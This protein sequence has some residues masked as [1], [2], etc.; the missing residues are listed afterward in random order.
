MFTADTEVFT[1]TNWKKI[2]DISG[3]DKLLV[4]NF[5]DE[6]SFIKPYS[7]RR[8]E[9]SGGVVELSGTRWAVNV[10]PD[11]VVPYSY[12]GRNGLKYRKRPALMVRGDGY[13]MASRKFR[14]VN[15]NDY[16]VENIEIIRDG[17]KHRTRINTEDWFRLCGYVICR[18]QLVKASPKRPILRIF[19]DKQKMDQEII[20]LGGI[21]DRIGIPWSVIPQNGSHYI[22]VGTRN[23]LSTRLHYRLGSMTRKEMFIPDKMIQSSRHLVD[24]LLDS[25]MEATTRIDTPKDRNFLLFTP[26]TNLIKSLDNLSTLWHMSFSANKRAEAGEVHGLYELQNDSYC[27]QIGKGTNNPKVRSVKPKEYSGTLYDIHLFDG[28]IYAR[29]EGGGIWVNPK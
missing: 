16:T 2:G 7:L 27:V 11:H 19:L 5:I 20:L 14:F 3:K 13:H 15:D 12:E 18:G 29:T 26:N 28:Q 23:G 21:L 10:T 24:I 6:A 1:D 4:R 9:Y 25:I 22:R 8:Q 17:V